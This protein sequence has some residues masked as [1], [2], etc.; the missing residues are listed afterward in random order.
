VLGRVLGPWGLRGEVKVKTFEESPALL[1]PGRAVIL[2]GP[3]GQSEALLR[4]V[5][6]VRQGLIAQFRGIDSR[7]AAEAVRGHEICILRGAAP[8]LPE[9]TYYHYDVLGLEVQT[10][11][12]ERLGKIVDIWPSAGHDLYVVRGD[13][14]EWMLPAVRA[15]VLRVDLA[16]RVMVVRTIEGLVDPETV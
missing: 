4:E 9:A 3:R 8:P 1:T 16:R 12:G 15:F 6:P 11:M 13:R 5:R 10:E 7:E 14:G 2:R